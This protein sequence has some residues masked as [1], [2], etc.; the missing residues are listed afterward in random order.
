MTLKYP[1]THEFTVSVRDKLGAESTRELVIYDGAKEVETI[2][3]AS[4][5]GEPQAL[6]K[7]VKDSNYISAKAEDGVTDAIT[8]VSQQPF[9]GGENPTIIVRH[10]KHLSRIT[11]TQSHW[12]Q[13]MRMYKHY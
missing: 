11:T 9:E 7:A 1:G 12:I 8:D 2:T 13:S 5:A 10:L 4:G 3:F 6:E